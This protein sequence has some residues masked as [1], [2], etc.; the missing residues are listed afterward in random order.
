MRVT[1]LIPVGILRF[2]LPGD[3]VCWDSSTK[4]LCAVA[5]A[6]IIVVDGNVFLPGI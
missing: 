4:I 2:R 3:G 1:Y 5:V 6:T